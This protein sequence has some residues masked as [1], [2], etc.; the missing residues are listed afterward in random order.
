MY[1]ADHSK[2][3][4]LKHRTGLG[5]FGWAWSE[6]ENAKCRQFHPDYAALAEALPHRTRQAIK[7]RC[8]DLKLCSPQARPWTAQEQSK[9]RRLY[10]TVSVAELREAF[11]DRSLSSLHNR[12]AELS[13]RRYRPPY[14][15][16][17]DRLLDG[18]REECSRRK[19]TMRDVDCLAKS[20]SYFTD[21]GWQGKGNSYYNY[22]W[23]VRAIY[24]LG[25]TLKVEWSEQ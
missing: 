11:P 3:A 24:A 15:S 16:T 13:L 14:T 9:L 20:G 4:G 22:R 19:L 10:K 25:G 8:S 2:N 18:L 12:G 23:I 6:E 1:L 17:G 5:Q 7:R 21:R